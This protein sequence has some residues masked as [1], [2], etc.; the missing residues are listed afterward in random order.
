MTGT[1]GGAA[2]GF[3]MLNSDK[4]YIDRTYYENKHRMP[5]IRSDFAC[6]LESLNRVTL[7]DISDGI[8]NEANEIA[9][10]HTSR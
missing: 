4:Y 2:A 10:P 5:Y 9:T 1:L 3:H 8:A 6:Q 7:N